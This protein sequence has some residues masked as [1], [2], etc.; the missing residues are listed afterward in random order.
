MV[1]FKFEFFGH[2][3]KPASGFG[4]QVRRRPRFIYH[5]GL[6]KSALNRCRARES[7][8]PAGPTTPDRQR[9][10]PPSMQTLELTIEL[11]TLLRFDFQ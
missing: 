6:Q 3:F 9:L 2:M 11:T 7:K 5:L 4:A 8:G 10:M 1:L